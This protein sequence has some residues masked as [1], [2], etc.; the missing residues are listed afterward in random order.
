MALKYFVMTFFYR[1]YR[2]IGLIFKLN[3]TGFYQSLFFENEGKDESI[4]FDYKL[5]KGD[6]IFDLGAF[7]GEFSEKVYSES[8]RFYLFD[9]NPKM[10]KY[11]NKKFKGKKNVSVHPFGLGERDTHG[12]TRL[13]IFPW[14]SA[15]ASYEENKN[16]KLIVK[17]FIKFCEEYKINEIEV[18]KINIEGAEYNLM[19]YLYKNKFLKNI[20]H[21]QIQPHDFDNE[22]LNNLLELHRNLHKTHKLKLSYPFVWDF[23]ERK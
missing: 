14:A 23:W 5:S 2:K 4:R 11:L 20:N 6:I 9:T 8:S 21:I 1:L 17:D 18:L 3:F 10:V 16:E 19:K 22:S 7:K 12:S 13:P 15:G